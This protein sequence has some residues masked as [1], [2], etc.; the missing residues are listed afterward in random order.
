MG[1]CVTA[2]IGNIVF[3]LENSKRALDAINALH[4]E[5]AMVLYGAVRDSSGMHYAWVNYPKEGFKTLEEA[6]Y[7]WRYSTYTARDTG[8]VMVESFEGEKFGD[9]EV[10]WATLAKFVEPS[11]HATITWR[12]EDGHMWRYQISDGILHEQTATISWE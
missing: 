11:E 10:L 6:L 2:D 4:T 8:A 9:D 12:G 3:S 7:G 5:R 1:Y